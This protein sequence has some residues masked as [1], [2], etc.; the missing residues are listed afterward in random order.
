MTDYFT[1]DDLTK[2]TKQKKRVKAVYYIVLGLYLALSVALLVYYISL[3]YSGYKDTESTV[4][5]I[6]AIEYV[7]S[8]LFVIF[9]FIYLGIKYKRTKRFYKMCYNMAT[10]LRETSTGSFFEYDEKIQDKDGVD[11]K[12]LI[13]LE[14]NKYKQE[15]FERK[16]LVFYEKPF[17]EIPPEAN[18]TYVTQGNVLVS[19]EILS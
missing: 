17:P 10:G 15:F 6:K 3:P 12:S 14:W 11:F 8:G 2:V 16:V 7:A 9:S 19:Y 18:V 4:T 1:E 5:L 13:F